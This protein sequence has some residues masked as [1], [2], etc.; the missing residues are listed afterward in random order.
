MSCTIARRPSGPA[1]SDGHRFG[2]RPTITHE[3]IL[4]SPPPPHPFPL[5]LPSP[6][7]SPLSTSRSIPVQCT[8]P[9]S[10]LS[11][12]AGPATHMAAARNNTAPASSTADTREQ[13]STRT[14]MERR[15]EAT[16]TRGEPAPAC[17][18]SAVLSGTPLFPAT[19]SDE[20]DPDLGG[21][22]DSNS[23]SMTNA[24]SAVTPVFSS[25]QRVFPG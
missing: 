14:S 12:H 21:W 9:S 24:P 25:E 20:V 22:V 4:G 15:G 8:A 18:A 19:P 6:A 7:T 3:T 1:A 17:N 10:L 23:E 11:S 5:P 13:S 2:F 16:V